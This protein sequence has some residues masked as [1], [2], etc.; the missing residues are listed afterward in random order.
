MLPFVMIYCSYTALVE[1][2][3]AVYHQNFCTIEM[4]ILNTFINTA[5]CYFIRLKNKVNPL[6]EPGFCFQHCTAKNSCRRPSKMK[7]TPPTVKP[8]HHRSHPPTPVS[9]IKDHTSHQGGITYSFVLITPTG[10][11]WQ[12][13]I[14]SLINSS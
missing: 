14:W 3:F 11:E 6:N 13:R 8:S 10:L 2:L 9:C 5:R 7:N 4:M 12:V 1:L